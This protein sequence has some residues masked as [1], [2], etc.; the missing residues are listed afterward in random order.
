MRV[1]TGV[2]KGR[3]VEKYIYNIEL[4]QSPSYVILF[5]S[6]LFDHV[7]ALSQ[8]L[9]NNCLYSFSASPVPPPSSCGR[10]LGCAQ[11]GVRDVG[12]EN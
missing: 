6:V 5:V 1:V 3:L 7:P 9:R 11:G 8:L 2:Y 12:A 10:L 4:Q